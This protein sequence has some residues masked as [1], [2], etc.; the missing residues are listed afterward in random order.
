SC[1]ACLD[2]CPTD[3]FPQSY[4]LDASRC[5]SYLTIETARKSRST[6]EMES[7]IGSSVV[8]CAKKSAPGTTAPQKLRSRRISRSLG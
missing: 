1:T 2:A 7:V 3:A 5:I 8:M 4:V 6:S